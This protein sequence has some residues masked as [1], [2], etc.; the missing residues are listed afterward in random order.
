ME[1]KVPNPRW[2][3]MRGTAYARTAI[4]DFVNDN[5][6]NLSEWL[7]RVAQGVP[8]ITEDGKLIR[9]ADGSIAYLVK[10]DAATAIKIVSD[11]CE[12]HLP[13]LSRQDVSVSGVVASLD[14]LSP[15]AATLLSMSQL[16]LTAHL[17]SLNAPQ[18]LPAWLAGHPGDTIDVT[19]MERHDD[20]KS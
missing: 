12:Y 17:R 3:K 16:D 20:D 11:I 1:K 19:P 2:A 9:E 8:K 13:K 5:A 18:A 7:N 14:N 15:A 10:P 6:D 4:G